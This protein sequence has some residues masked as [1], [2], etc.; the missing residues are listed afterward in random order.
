MRCS[1]V[2]PAI[3]P[4]RSSALVLSLLALVLARPSGA[5]WQ[6]DG[7]PLSPMPVGSETNSFRGVIPDG[8]GG[9]GAA[10]IS[11]AEHATRAAEG[12]TGISNRRIPQ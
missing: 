10:P 8:T 4:L 3:R 1:N 12:G 9:A 5:A 2:S 11:R 6:P 7:V